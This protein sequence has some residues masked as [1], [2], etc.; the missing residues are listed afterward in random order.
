[1]P[2]FFSAVICRH[3]NFPLDF[4]LSI[5]RTSSTLSRTR[6][7][8]R[9]TAKGVRPQQCTGYAHPSQPAPPPPPVH[10]TWVPPAHLSLGAPS[11]YLSWGTP[12]TPQ[13]G[14]GGSTSG[15]S[16]HRSQGALCTPQMGGFPAQLRWGWALHTVTPQLG[17]PCAPQ[18][19]VNRILNKTVLLHDRKRRTAHTPR[20]R[21]HFQCQ[22]K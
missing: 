6:Q 17:G 14:G 21:V 19:G 7:S 12:C 16:T 20:L 11:V 4:F 8:S 13:P 9:V 5:L 15:S 18:P 3:I 10:L 2:A 1:M 22:K